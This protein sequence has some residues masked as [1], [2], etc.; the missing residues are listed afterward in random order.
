[1]NDSMQAFLVQSPVDDSN[2]STQVDFEENDP[3]NPINFTR[4][5]KWVITLTT[6]AFLALAGDSPLFFLL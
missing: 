3:R 4:T 6:T 1:M 2:N 5:R